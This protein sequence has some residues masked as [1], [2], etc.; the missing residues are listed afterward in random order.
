[1]SA[2]QID[3]ETRDIIEKCRAAY[4]LRGADKPQRVARALDVVAYDLRYLLREGCT[5]PVLSDYGGEE[6][7]WALAVVKALR[8][9]YDM[10]ENALAAAFLE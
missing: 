9:A 3:K 10:Q 1:M 8:R 7:L 4:I 2:E 6:V 5:P